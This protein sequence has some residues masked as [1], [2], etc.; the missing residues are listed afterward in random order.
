VLPDRLDRES[1]ETIRAIL[2]AVDVGGR[3]R[4]IRDF[5]WRGG[6]L[7]FTIEDQ[8]AWYALTAEWD[9]AVLERA[10]SPAIGLVPARDAVLEGRW[11]RARS[12]YRLR[13]GVDLSV[14]SAMQIRSRRLL[15]HVPFVGRSPEEVEH[16]LQLEL[17][18]YAEAFLA[19]CQPVPQAAEEAARQLRRL[20]LAA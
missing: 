2:D 11:I 13:V 3:L 9:A 5:I 18:A 10:Q 15:S 20:G 4:Y 7:Q 1:F 14:P 17:A 19:G 12:G 16:A 8:A 6:T